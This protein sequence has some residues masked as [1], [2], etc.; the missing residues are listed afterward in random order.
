MQCA[1]LVE[2]TKRYIKPGE[3][4]KVN[5]Y[6]D[7]AGEA[8]SHAGKSDWQMVREYFARESGYF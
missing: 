8:R 6:G 4:L 1:S 5:I 3:Q 7:A 2:K